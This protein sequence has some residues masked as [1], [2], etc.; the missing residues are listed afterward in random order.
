MSNKAIQNRILADQSL[1][2]GVK[3]H[4][5]KGHHLVIDGEKLGAAEIRASCKVVSTRRS[6]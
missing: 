2:G 4:I 5:A 1:L 6:A 3:K